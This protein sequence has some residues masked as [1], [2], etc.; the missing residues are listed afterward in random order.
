M[1]DLFYKILDTMPIFISICSVVCFATPTPSPD[2]LL[3]KAYKVIEI[4]AFNF[5]RA[6][7]K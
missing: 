1:I 6:K 5:G 7:D 3:G 2:T 4:I